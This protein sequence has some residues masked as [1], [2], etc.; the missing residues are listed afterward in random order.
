MCGK[1]VGA[2]EQRLQDV[3]TTSNPKKH[4]CLTLPTNTLTQ[5]PSTRDNHQFQSACLQT[6]AIPA[7]LRCDINICGLCEAKPDDKLHF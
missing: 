6:G 5:K 1:N 3:C 7:L 2:A 4:K